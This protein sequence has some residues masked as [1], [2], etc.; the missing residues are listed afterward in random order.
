M[1]GLQPASSTPRGSTFY[2]RAKHAVT[3][4]SSGG[5]P[6]AGLRLWHAVG[7]ALQGGGAKVG[8]ALVIVGR[9]SPY[10]AWK[11][12]LGFV[13]SLSFR[14]SLFLASSAELLH[15]GGTDAREAVEVQLTGGLGHVLAPV[16]PCTRAHPL[17][18][19]TGE[20]S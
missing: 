12:A 4:G 8:K 13:S 15:G 11:I 14:G 5:D 20:G 2:T 19:G 18:R 3:L 9:Q 6:A 16:F 10:A 1:R 17:P 7:F